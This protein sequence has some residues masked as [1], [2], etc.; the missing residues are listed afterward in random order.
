VYKQTNAPFRRTGGSC[1]GKNDIEIA[2]AAHNA[3]P[4]VDGGDGLANGADGLLDEARSR[5]PQ[6]VRDKDVVGD[7]TNVKE[8]T[9]GLHT[10]E[11]G[12]N[13][14][15]IGMSQTAIFGIWRP[16]ALQPHR[17][18]TFKL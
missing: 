8:Q 11:H 1:E 7:H 6:K 4:W 2:Q 10:L 9:E 14:K 13:G 3:K 18:E 12:R 17:T 16:F 15:R 5:A